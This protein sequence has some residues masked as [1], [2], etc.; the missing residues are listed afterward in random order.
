MR[1]D[2][3][4]PLPAAG[5]ANI[6]GVGRAAAPAAG[7][8]ARAGNSGFADAL[9]Q[10][11]ETVNTDQNRADA[12]QRAY[13]TGDTGVSLE[14]TMLATQSANVSFQALVQVRNRM[15]SAYHDIMNMQV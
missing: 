13:Q 4:T 2:P 1:M 14:E 7:A 11:L 10:A 8:A 5:L 3:I 12:L 15:V 6:A 9:K